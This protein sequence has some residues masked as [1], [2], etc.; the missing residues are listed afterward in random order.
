MADHPNELVI[1]TEAELDADAGELLRA[2]VVKGALHCS[3]KPTIWPDPGN[4]GILLADVA[5]HVARAIQLHDGR[6]PTETVARITQ[7]FNVEIETPTDKPDGEF[8]QKH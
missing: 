5:R 4:W 6:L 2:W 7:V 3:I 1:P 8:H